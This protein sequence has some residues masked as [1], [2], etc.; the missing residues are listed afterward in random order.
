MKVEYSKRAT[1]DL[2]KAAEE[3]RAFGQG[4]AASVEAR[5]REII[6]RIAEYPEAAARVTERPGMRVIP[7]IRYPYKIFYR[8]IEDGNGA[9]P[10]VISRAT[11]RRP[12]NYGAVLDCASCCVSSPILLIITLASG[13][14][15]VI[16]SVPPRAST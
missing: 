9:P 12:S 16:S 15:A 2:R 13:K 10:D 4:N 3:S 6:A 1:G 8:V 5:F 11:P 7:L 14:R